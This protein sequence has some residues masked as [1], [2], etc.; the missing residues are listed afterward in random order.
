MA[1]RVT[2]YTTRWC[3]YCHAAKSLLQRRDIGYD[4]VDLSDDPEARADVVRRAGGYRQVPTIFIDDQFIG[5]YQEL[6]A[7][8]QSGELSAKL[9]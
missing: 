7:L 2:V 5:G 8:D 1:M 4:E 9:S 3:G 6:R